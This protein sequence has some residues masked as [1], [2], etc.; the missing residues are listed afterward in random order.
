[1]KDY[2]QQVIAFKDCID[3]EFHKQIVSQS[4][5][6]ESNQPVAR[7]FES[8]NSEEAQE[9]LSSFVGDGHLLVCT[10]LGY[11]VLYQN[12]ARNALLDASFLPGI[13]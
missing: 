8:A 1:M 5:C 6:G 3:E 2:E 13:K 11:G 9:G 12:V 7:R 10:A 4:C